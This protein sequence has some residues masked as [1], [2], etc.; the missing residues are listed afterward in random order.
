ML[1]PYIVIDPTLPDLACLINSGMQL[2]ALLWVAP[3]FLI[4]SHANCTCKPGTT[5]D[6]FSFIKNNDKEHYHIVINSYQGP[7]TPSLHRISHCH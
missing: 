4:R 5:N 2:H 6:Q 7:F 3:L 1:L